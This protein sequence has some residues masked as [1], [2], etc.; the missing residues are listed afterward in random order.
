MGV[1]IAIYTKKKTGFVKISFPALL[2]SNE[3]Q[4]VFRWAAVWEWDLIVSVR[5]SEIN[6]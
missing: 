3:P 1:V 5:H 4:P 2:I 6:F